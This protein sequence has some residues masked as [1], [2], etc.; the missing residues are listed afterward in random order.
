MGLGR[1]CLSD[2]AVA[3]PDA[4]ARSVARRRIGARR[5]IA[6]GVGRWR[7]VVHGRIGP[8]SFTVLV[9]VG[10]RVASSRAAVHGRSPIERGIWGDLAEPGA[11]KPAACDARAEYED[12]NPRVGGYRVS[13][14]R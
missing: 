6:A 10:R 5:G 12:T 8:S 9:G 11:A 7:D 3:G 1:A 4:S 14:A 13:A 2:G